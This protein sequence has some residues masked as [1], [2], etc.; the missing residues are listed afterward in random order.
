MIRLTRSVL[1][2]SKLK[3]SGWLEQLARVVAAKW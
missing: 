1:N 3:T 2:G